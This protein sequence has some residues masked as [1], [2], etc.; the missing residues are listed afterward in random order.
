MQRVCA[1]VTLIMVKH[2]CSKIIEQHRECYHERI[3][4][5]IFGKVTDLG[6]S[7]ANNMGA[8][9]APAAASTVA[10]HLKDT[11]RNADYYDLIITGDLGIF[12]SDI[13][14]TLMKEEGIVPGKKYSDCGAM[15][16]KKQPR[17]IR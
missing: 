8:A 17:K 1:S 3:I 6:I 9:M 14:R 4:F 5:G 10:A 16:Y 13:M 2:Q 7:D 11:G 15:I 12:G